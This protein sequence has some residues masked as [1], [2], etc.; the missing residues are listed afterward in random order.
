MIAIPSSIKMQ[1]RHA[2]GMLADLSHEPQ[3]DASLL[4]CRLLDKDRAWLLSHGNDVL[5][6]E[7]AASYSLLIARRQQNEPIQ[8][9]L[10]E[11]EFYGLRFAVTPAVLIPRPETEHLVEAVLARL[12][13]DAPVRI[14][15]VGTGSGAIAVALAHS[16]PL[17]E[18]EALDI[19]PDALKVAVQN[20]RAHGVENRVHCQHSDLLSAVTGQQFDA[21]ISNP[22]YIAWSDVLEPQVAEWE[23]HGALFAGPSGFEIYA[24]LIPQAAGLLKPGG[25]LALEI[26]F[27]Q[28]AEIE[29][30]LCK[31][32]RW[33]ASHFQHDL[34]GIPRVACVSLSLPIN[35]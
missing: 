7:Q 30:L 31:D 33:S 17:A 15:D 22:P 8:Y 1:L 23:P 18:V 2:A 20:A 27:G 14:A 29:S 21:I 6:E 4:L 16:L 24:R 26:G 35:S 12:P 28:Q 13:H 3:R 32:R 5:T 25:L 11:Q 10:G 34:Q 9:I 19:S